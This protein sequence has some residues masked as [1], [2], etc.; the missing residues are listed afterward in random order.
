MACPRKRACCNFNAIRSTGKIATH[1]RVHEQCSSRRRAAAPSR[2]TLQRTPARPQRCLGPEARAMPRRN[3]WQRVPFVSARQRLPLATNGPCQLTFDESIT[4]SVSCI[5]RCLN[6]RPESRLADPYDVRLDQEAPRSHRYDSTA[7]TADA[8][9]ELT[10]QVLK[11][12]DN[13]HGV[14]LR[15]HATPTA[16]HSCVTQTSNERTEAAKAPT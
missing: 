3:L 14:D 4:R 1:Q 2:C 12:L 7:S 5:S 15:E 8:R 11:Q 9:V 13:L 10:T 16:N 6:R